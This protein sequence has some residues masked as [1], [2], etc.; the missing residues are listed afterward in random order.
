MRLWELFDDNTTMDFKALVKEASRSA[1]IKP[2][3]KRNPAQKDSPKDDE[4][5]KY[6]LL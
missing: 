6:G 3:A 4:D 2:V 5:T 1:V